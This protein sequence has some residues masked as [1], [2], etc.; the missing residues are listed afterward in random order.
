MGRIFSLVSDITASSGTLGLLFVELDISV[1]FASDVGAFVMACNEPSCVASWLRRPL[2][3]A[4][5][6][7]SGDSD[8]VGSCRAVCASP[9][10][11]ASAP[12]IAPRDWFTTEVHCV[13]CHST[14][15]R[16]EAT[17]TLGA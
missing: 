6:S 14:S 15:L 12:F 10:V 2:G 13:Y 7:G 8:G 3:N 16:G 1:P 4:T 9:F 17:V 11:R 5:S